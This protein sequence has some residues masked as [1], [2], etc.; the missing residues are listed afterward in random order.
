MTAVI[1]VALVG[2]ILTILSYFEGIKRERKRV[3]RILDTYEHQAE[4]DGERAKVI[5]ACS[6]RRRVRD[7]VLFK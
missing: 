5:A 1:F 6:I 2:A 4:N 7:P 3:F